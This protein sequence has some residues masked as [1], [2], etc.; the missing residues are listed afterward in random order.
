MISP[1]VGLAESAR[2]L[3]TAERRAG[4]F[5]FQWLWAGPNSRNVNAWGK[6]AM[7]DNYG[8]EVV[9]CEFKV[10]E[11]M[12][13][14][15]RGIVMDSTCS[16]W[17]QASGNII[18]TLRATRL[19]PRDV[20]WYTNVPTRRGNNVEPWP[21]DGRL[22]FTSL[23]KIEIVMVPVAAVS[24]GANGGFGYGELLGHEYPES[25]AGEG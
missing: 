15:L 17:E 13:F 25:E 23:E 1:G 18:F 3:G 4:R 24:L 9:I 22:E 19:G 21:I 16:D 5:P 7:P 14:S 2:T 11:G 6:A 12:R 20:E 8:D 10:S